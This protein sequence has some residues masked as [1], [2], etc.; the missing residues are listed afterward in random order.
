M[1]QIPVSKENG[2]LATEK[3]EFSSKNTSMHFHDP[4]LS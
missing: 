4:I 3:N 1:S 2:C